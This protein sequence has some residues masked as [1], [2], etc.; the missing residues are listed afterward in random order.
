MNPRSDNERLQ[1][2]L[3]SEKKINERMMKSQ[4]EMN[5]LNEKNLCRQKGKGG[6]G[7]T[8]EGESSKQ[9]AQKNQIPTCNHCGKIGHT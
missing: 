6:I 5:K 9:G 3:N 7:Y 8:K 1:N 4:V 2:D